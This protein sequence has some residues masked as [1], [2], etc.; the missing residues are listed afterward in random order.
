[1]GATAAGGRPAD[2][3]GHAGPLFRR[4]CRFDLLVLRPVRAIQAA[5]GRGRAAGTPVIIE[6]TPG[7]GGPEGPQSAPEAREGPENRPGR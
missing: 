6:I 2:A 5:V 3:M 1:M 4:K 7:P